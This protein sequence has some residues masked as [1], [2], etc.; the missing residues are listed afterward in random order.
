MC[1]T[2]LHNLVSSLE[3]LVSNGRQVLLEDI[4]LGGSVTL[5][6]RGGHEGLDRVQTKAEP[7]NLMP[8]RSTCLP[9]DTKYSRDDTKL[10]SFVDDIP[11]ENSKIYIFP[12]GS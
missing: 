7:L 4:R 11:R 10:R 9:L 12:S 1:W 8:P 3:Y 2:E 5:M 6:A